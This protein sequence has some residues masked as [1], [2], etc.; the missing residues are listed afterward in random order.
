MIQRLVCVNREM[1]RGKEILN[2]ANLT[3]GLACARLGEDASWIR[4]PSELLERD[5]LPLKPTV[6]TIMFGTND[7]HDGEQALDLHLK[8]LAQII[9]RLRDANCRVILLSA[10][11]EE[12]GSAFNAEHEKFAAAVRAL[13]ERSNVP[14]VDVFHPVLRLV[15]QA[16]RTDPNFSYTRD[17]Y[18]PHPSGHAIIARTIASGLGL[19]A[20]KLNP[21]SPSLAKVTEKN[22]AYFGRWRELQIPALLAGRLDSAETRRQLAEADQRIAE[23]E[24]EINSL[25]RP[26]SEDAVVH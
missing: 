12:I 11:P 5:V 6:A 15:Q 3:A 1:N 10:P 21:E 14:F 20:D 16:K 7:A 9:A 19:D 18:H 8:S 2:R 24:S 22:R 25:R 17:G 23:L 4:D 26:N 13:S